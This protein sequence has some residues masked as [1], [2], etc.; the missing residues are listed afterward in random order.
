MR[1]VLKDI[2]NRIREKE[3]DANAGSYF[4]ERLSGN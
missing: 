2:K 3:T 1:M 4:K